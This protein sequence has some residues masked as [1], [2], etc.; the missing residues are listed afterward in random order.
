MSMPA[1]EKQVNNLASQRR[2]FCDF[3]GNPGRNRPERQALEPKK[4]GESM[5]PAP[6]RPEISC[7][8][9]S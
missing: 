2:W 1:G 3:G 6:N 7:Q 5:P 4:K 8:T 9:Q